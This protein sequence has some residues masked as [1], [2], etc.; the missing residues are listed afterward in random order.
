GYFFMPADPALIEC[1][2]RVS[3]DVPETNIL[4]Y[5]TTKSTNDISID[6]ISYSSE[7]EWEPS[8]IS[9][10]IDINTDAVGENFPI[11]IVGSPSTLAQSYE[12][13]INISGYFIQKLLEISGSELD[14][15]CVNSEMQ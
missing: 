1:A 7:Q 5:G 12:A 10:E 13:C 11:E 8:E 3:E 14:G 15:C 2:L 6:S 4:T 9:S